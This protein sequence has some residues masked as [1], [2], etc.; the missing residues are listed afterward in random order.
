M[1]VA[2]LVTTALSGGEWSSLA[3]SVLESRWRAEY[4]PAARRWEAVARQF[5]ARGRYSF[6]WFDGSTTAT[7]NLSVAS[8]GDRKLYILDQLFLEKPNKAP[9]PK[10][11]SVECQTSDYDFTLKKSVGAENYTIVSHGMHKT[12]D[13]P[14]TETL[15]KRFARN[16]TV[17]EGKA[18]LERMQAPSF[19][20]KTIAALDREGGEIVR[21]GYDYESKTQFES[22][23]V[24]LEPAKDWA[25]CGADLLMTGKADLA[26]YQ[27]KL[28][29][30]YGTFG[31]R[32]LFPKRMEFDGRLSDPKIYQHAIVEY[33]QVKFDAPP[34]DLFKL[35]H[36]ELPDLPVRISPRASIFTLK[37]PIFWVALGSA[38]FCF[39]FL[40]RLRWRRPRAS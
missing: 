4:P 10:A 2:I 37:N 5:E 15:F 30:V 24:D 38:L 34:D 6:H 32:R 13:S 29:V 31:D 16:A 28:S 27:F 33:D 26:P 1:L 18:F 12:D 21:V 11:T 7:R 3:P 40:W 17:Y 22:G 23:T 9:A 25:I 19:S 8:S 20:L 36:Y 14:N 39:A 35:S